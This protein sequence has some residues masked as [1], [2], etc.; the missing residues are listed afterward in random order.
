MK[1]W[2]IGYDAPASDKNLPKVV[3]QSDR[4]PTEREAEIAVYSVTYGGTVYIESIDETSES[5]M[6]GTKYT[7]IGAKQ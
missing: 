4:E 2:L 5:A 7:L 6:R 3:M 1:L